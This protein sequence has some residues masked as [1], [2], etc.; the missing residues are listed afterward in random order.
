MNAAFYGS[1]SILSSPENTG[2]ATPFNLIG[3]TLTG[4]EATYCGRSLLLNLLVP[5]SKVLVV[6][7]S[8]NLTLSSFNPMIFLASSV[9]CPA[10]SKAL[11]ACEDLP[12]L[13]ARVLVSRILIL[14]RQ[15]RDIFVLP[16]L[17]F[18]KL[19][20]LFLYLLDPS[21]RKSSLLTCQQLFALHESWSRQ[22][23][24]VLVH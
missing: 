5:A 14:H 11:F 3:V 16:G 23:L 20:K 13:F 22:L 1:Y 7:L 24:R 4:C 6:S 9:Q 19:L 2:K 21:L 10:S 15:L 18:G 17:T 8:A 12:K